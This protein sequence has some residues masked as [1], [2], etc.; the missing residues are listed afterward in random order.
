[1]ISDGT[2]TKV[3]ELDEDIDLGDKPFREAVFSAKITAHK[4]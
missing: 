3:V 2:K 4:P 1:V